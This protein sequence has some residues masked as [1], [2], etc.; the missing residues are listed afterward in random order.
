MNKFTNLARKAAA[1]GIILLKNDNSILPVTINDEVAVFGRCQIDYYRSGTGSGGSVNVPYKVN[2]I[3]GLTNN[4]NI[5]INNYLKNIY[6]EFVRNN[7]FDNGG[8]GWAAEPWYQKEME[9]SDNVLDKVIETSNKAIIIIGRTAGEDKD[10]S[11][12]PGS[13]YLTEEELGIVKKVTSKF[14]NVIIVFNVSNILDMK[15]LTTIENKENIKSIL[16]SWQGGM[17]GGNAL[18]DVISGNITPSGKLTDTI[19]YEINQYPAYNNFGN[20]DKDIYQEDI[21]IGYRYFETF[22]KDAVQYPFGFGLSYTNF[23]I[24]PLNSKI[25]KQ[26][27]N[28]TLDLTIK[29]TNVGDKFSGKEVVQL[30]YQCPQGLLG[31]PSLQLGAFEKTV[32]L[33]PKESETILLSIPVSRMASYDDL[34]LTGYK[35]SYI[36]EKGEYKIFIGNSIRNITPVLFDNANYTLNETI[37]VETLNQAMTP[38]IEFKRYK[39]GTINSDGNYSLTME[40]VDSNYSVLEERMNKWMPQ[41][42]EITGDRGIKLIDV[43]NGQF[44]IEDFISQLSQKELEIIVRGEG[45]SS[46]KVTSGT[47]GAFGGVGDSLIKFG[48]PIACAADGPSG[49]RRD[50]GELATQLPIGTLLAS[51]WDR[52]LIE[53][54][55]TYE[56]EELVL[57]EIDTLLG[58]GMNIHRH[59][60]NGRNF[61]YFS[62]DPYVTGIMACAVTLGLEKGGSTGTVKHFACNDQEFNRSVVDS[63]VSERALREIHLK[64]FEYVVKE[65]HAK[66]LMTSYNP[67]NGIWAASNYDLNTTI[68]RKEWKY[69]GIVMTDWWAKMND[70]IE[71][72]EPSVKNMSSM[73]RAQ[74]DIY[75]LVNNY[76]AEVNG[77]G[78]DLTESIKSGV[79]TIGEL[80]Q[81]AKNICN[82][83]INSKCID[84]PIKK[85][86]IKF[87]KSNEINNSNY[88]VITSENEI[89]LNTKIDKKLIL[90]IKEECEYSLV[91]HMCYDKDPGA[92]SSFNI[93]LNNEYITNVQLNGTFG[94]WVKQKD[95]NVH[96]SKGF[97]ILDLNFTKPGIEV[98]SL[99][100]IKN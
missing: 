70:P 79:L 11:A 20:P 28:T 1:E 81:C 50:S 71:G 78:D 87:I 26:N 59:P 9:I 66:S 48:I 61:E 69:D 31:K 43:K 96:L 83:I 46:P 64:P 93:L 34:G 39:P 49:I 65:G 36:L 21:Y 3:D 75:M 32:D 76:G 40:N 5:I 14:E 2:A 8:G 4:K 91:I 100:F 38:K 47:A 74:N 54:L 92:Q 30:Y 23:N 86:T 42:L 24:E 73:V 56:G 29:V 97:Y 37:L 60:L 88:E 18:A 72:G 35:S 62:E 19:A 13:Y 58:P 41:P 57:N 84:R 6:E 80:Q 94:N 90:E 22:N 25:N 7:P 10:N 17:E 89:L 16:Y 51:T 63:V 77:L 99:S 27:N 85:P 95:L 33:K 98:G 53:E 45:M 15:W 52:K 82:F 55:Y 12:K 44:T 68:L 67:I